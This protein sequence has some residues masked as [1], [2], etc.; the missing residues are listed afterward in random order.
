MDKSRKGIMRFLGLARYCERFVPELARISKP[1]TRM[2]KKDVDV[3]SEWGEDQDKAVAELKEALS[4][5]LVLQR[6]D[7]SRPVLVQTDASDFA[8][9]AV[10]SHYEGGG[11][12]R[13]EYPIMFASKTLNKHQVNY[14]VT[15]KECLAVVWALDQF[16]PMILGKQFL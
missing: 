8:V 11:A 13:K 6:F 2:L 3:K 7:P 9:G 1:L 10:I 5:D 15:E 12:D 16:R 4:G 14:S